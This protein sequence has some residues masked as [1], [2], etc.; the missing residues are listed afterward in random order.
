MLSDVR[1]DPS[2]EVDLPFMDQHSS[3]EDIKEDDEVRMEEV[4]VGDETIDIPSDLYTNPAIFHQFFSVDTWNDLLPE[5]VKLR[6]LKLLPSFDH[7]DIDEKAKTIEMLF[8][9]ENF[10]FGNPIDKFRT[11][12]LEGDFSLERRAMKSI[13]REGRERDHCEWLERHRMLLVQELLDSRKLLLEEATGTQVTSPRIDTRLAGAGGLV[14]QRVRKR[15][16][17][18]VTRIKREVGEMGLSSDDEDCEEDRDDSLHGQQIN[19]ELSSA[20][21]L[22]HDPELSQAKGLNHGASLSQGPLLTQDLQPCFLALLR[23]LFLAS[24]TQCLSMDQLEQGVSTWQA[25]P[26]AALNPWYQVSFDIHLVLAFIM[27]HDHN[28]LRIVLTLVAGEWSLDQ[29]CLF[30]LVQLL[31]FPEGSCLC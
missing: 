29:L 7:D 28:Y 6:L 18:E 8:G 13:V 15:Y 4:V 12:L 22:T 21:E 9:A 20:A 23:E 25:S 24:P 19:K 27:I 5:E 2:V 30:S 3:I 16:L 14:R 11:E 31:I 17:D 1:D 26:I 10:H